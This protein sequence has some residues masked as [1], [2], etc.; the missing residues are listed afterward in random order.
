MITETDLY[1]M[2][3]ESPT[4]W[5]KMPEL[6]AA[7]GVKFPPENREPLPDRNVADPFKESK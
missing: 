1:A 7:L 6:C 2:E 4:A 5:Q 3:M